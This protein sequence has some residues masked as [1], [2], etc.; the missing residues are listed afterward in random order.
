MTEVASDGHHLSSF[1]RFFLSLLFFSSLPCSLSFFL[2]VFVPCSFLGLLIFHCRLFLF[3]CLHFAV[4]LFLP[5]L[6][7]CLL[8]SFLC[9]SFLPFLPLFHPKFFASVLRC[10]LH[11]FSPS[12][13]PPFIFFLVVVVSFFGFLPSSLT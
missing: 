4:L 6:L 8:L 10:L 12:S 5:T 3:S 1:F 13:V 7:A 11:P 2:S 9:S